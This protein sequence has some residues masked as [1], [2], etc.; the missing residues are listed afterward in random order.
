MIGLPQKWIV[1]YHFVFNKNHLKVILYKNLLYMWAYLYLKIDTYKK[2]QRAKLQDLGEGSYFEGFTK[3]VCHIKH[4]TFKLSERILLV[5][6][7]CVHTCLAQYQPF[8]VTPRHWVSGIVSHRVTQ[9]YT[10]LHQVTPSHTK[11]HRVTPTY[12]MLLTM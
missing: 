10:E 4:F 6:T 5:W 11:L 12:N 3:H 2:R 7:C 1:T 9:S 8:V